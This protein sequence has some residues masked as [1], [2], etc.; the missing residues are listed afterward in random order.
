MYRN[1]RCRRNITFEIYFGLPL[2]S[3][4]RKRLREGYLLNNII[5]CDPPIFDRFNIIILAKGKRFIAQ[6]IG[7]QTFNINIGK[8]QLTLERKPLSFC[9]KSSIFGYQATTRKNNIGGRFTASGCSI[10]I[11]GYATSRLLHN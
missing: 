8:S 5:Y 1:K 10:Y 9:Q 6:T 3:L 4:F 11:S 2:G 7:S